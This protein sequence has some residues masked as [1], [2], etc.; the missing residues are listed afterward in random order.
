MTSEAND[1]TFLAV[2]HCGPDTWML[3]A[4]VERAAD[5]RSGFEAFDDEKALRA[6]LETG[7]D[8]VVLLVNRKLDGWFDA[9]DGIELLSSV[10][11]VRRPRT[12]TVLVSDLADAQAAAEAAGARPGFGKRALND[13]ATLE[14][15]RNAAADVASA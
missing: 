15:L 8:A 14:A 11:A 5:G 13:P 4:T 1:T 9:T 2:G 3:K 12:A 10:L 6:R 7:D